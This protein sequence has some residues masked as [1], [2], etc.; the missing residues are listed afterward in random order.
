[1]GRIY[2]GVLG[3]VAFST[4]LLRGLVGGASSGQ[5]INATMALF[6]FATFGWIIGSVAEGTILQSVRATFDA[7]VAAASGGST[8]E[9]ANMSRDTGQT[10]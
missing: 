6:A 4:I 7:E 2:A 3:V 1:M 8:P 10:Q 5:M 9:T